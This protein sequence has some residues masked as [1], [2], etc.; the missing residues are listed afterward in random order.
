ARWVGPAVPRPRVRGV[1]PAAGQGELAKRKALALRAQRHGSRAG[2]LDVRSGWPAGDRAQA[3]SPGPPADG[4]P[5]AGTLALSAAGRALLG[6][7]KKSVKSAGKPDSVASGRPDVTAI[8]LGRLSPTGSVLPTRELPGAPD[9]R[10]RREPR[11]P[12]SPTWYCCA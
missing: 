12:R 11:P 2:A 3:H 7:S 10:P 5:G 9:G 6:V 8:P 4:R 1:G